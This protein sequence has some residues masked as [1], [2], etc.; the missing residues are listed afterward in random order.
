MCILT[1]HTFVD[2]V[3]STHVR[4]GSYERDRIVIWFTD[5]DRTNTY[6]RF[7]RVSCFPPL[8]INLSVSCGR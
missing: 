1:Y 5:I 3:V 2:D 6:H 7:R 8:T 4:G